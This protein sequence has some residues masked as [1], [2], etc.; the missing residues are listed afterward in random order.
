VRLGLYVAAF[1]T[2]A[3]L[4]RAH[5][6]GLGTELDQFAYTVGSALYTLAITV[7]FYLALE[8]WV[9]RYWPQVL[10]TS[11]RVLRDDWKNPRVGRDVLIGTALGVLFIT[12]IAVMQL[13]ILQIGRHGP[14][15]MYL[16]HLLGT[17][18]TIGL[19]SGYL[20]GAITSVTG[21]LLLGLFLR[22]LLRRE[23]LVGIAF[24]L[25]MAFFQSRNETRIAY[26]PFFLVNAGNYVIVA[27][28]ILRLGMFGSIVMIAVT[29][30]L[31]DG[32]LTTDLSAWYGTSTW[33]AIVV[34]I[35]FAL[36][37]YRVA[38]AGQPLLGDPAS[39]S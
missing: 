18:Y 7:I 14:E 15:G 39:D 11:T 20:G 1:D 24:V 8:P 30:I 36:W 16:A 25:I 33:I 21:L 19:F 38:T 6:Y 31:G 27:L 26:W 32:L 29:N 23:W 9:R 5:H 12:Y 35:A 34:T 2:A 28:A 10:V 22:G 37:G 17:R 13:A 3:R 4:L